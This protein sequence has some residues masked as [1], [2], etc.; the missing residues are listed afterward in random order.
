M[1]A[2]EREV[3]SKDS[4]AI[5]AEAKL[6]AGDTTRWSSDDGIKTTTDKAKSKK[7]VKTN[8]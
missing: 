6:I 3:S 2:L 4:E 1:E 8:G 7:R 5:I